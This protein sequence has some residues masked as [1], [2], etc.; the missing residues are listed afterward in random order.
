M[1]LDNIK[2]ADRSAFNSGIFQ[3]IPIAQNTGDSRRMSEINIEQYARKKPEGDQAQR[4]RIQQGYTKDLLSY[5]VALDVGVTFE[6]RTQ[7]KYPE[8]MSA[9]TSMVELPFNSMELDLQMRIANATAT[10]YSDMDGETVDTTTGDT[11]AWAYSGHLVRGT[12]DTYRNILANNPRLSSGAL[13]AMR[14]MAVENAIDQFGQKIIGINYDILWTT[15]DEEDIKIAEEYLH[16]TGSPD[17]D[18]PAVKNVWAYRFRHVI[19][20]RVA[21]TALGV[22][23]TSKRHYWGLCSSK[24][25]TAY[26]GI[27]EEPN[28]IPMFKKMDGSDNWETGVRAGFGICV[29]SGRGFCLSTGT[30]EA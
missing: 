5:R 24:Y 22:V 20:P 13:I 19:L 3:V 25:V 26:L 10:S 23:S 9:L 12:S 2:S 1:W 18:N 29:V 21:M 30:G 27:W 17:Y 15:D 28:V 4:L 7:N 14:R 11:Y 6:Q 16:S 8:V